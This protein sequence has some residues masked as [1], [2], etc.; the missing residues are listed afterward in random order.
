M[1]FKNNFI[2]YFKIYYIR[3]KNEIFII[4][5]K[6]KIYLKLLNFKIYRIRINNEGEYIFKTFINYFF[7]FEIK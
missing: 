2:F 5:L 1:I 6:F 4:F 3:Y 7:Q